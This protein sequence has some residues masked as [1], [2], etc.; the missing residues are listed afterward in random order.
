ML[1]LSAVAQTATVTDLFQA[2][3]YIQISSSFL[4]ILLSKEGFVVLNYVR[5]AGNGMEKKPFVLGFCLVQ[6]IA[7]AH[8]L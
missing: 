6:K 7:T 5:C 8:S 1:N 4:D 3:E 2:L